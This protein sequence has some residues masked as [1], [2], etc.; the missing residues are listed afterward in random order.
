MAVA[1]DSIS[2]I[3]FS[4]VFQFPSTFEQHRYINRRLFLGRVTK[5]AVKA[6]L[7]ISVCPS[8]ICDID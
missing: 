8:P 6:S 7:M 5:K 3:S 2:F 4:V 1:V